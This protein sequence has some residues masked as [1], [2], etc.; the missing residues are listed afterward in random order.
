MSIF[1]ASPGLQGITKITHFCT[2]IPRWLDITITYYLPYKS[3]VFMVPKPPKIAIFWYPKAAIKLQSRS[4]APKRHSKVAAK[5]HSRKVAS[6]QLSS[7]AGAKMPRYQDFFLRA[8]HFVHFPRFPWFAWGAQN[9]PFLHP[10]TEMA[11]YHDNLLFPIQKLCF[12][13]AKAT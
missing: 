9:H 8:R 12:H 5:Q 2:Q 7:Q 10:D 11:R 3:Y 1:L 6:Q 13:G 4:K